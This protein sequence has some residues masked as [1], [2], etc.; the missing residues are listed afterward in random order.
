MS[1]IFY[2]FQYR[3]TLFLAIEKSNGDAAVS[4]V[5][6]VVVVAVI[7]VV[8]PSENISRVVVV[9]CSNVDNNDGLADSSVLEQCG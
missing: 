5:V 3:F 6:V 2:Q 9:V 7:V 1:G 8:A 4:G